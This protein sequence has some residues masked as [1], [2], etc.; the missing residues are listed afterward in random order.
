MVVAETLASFNAVKT[1]FDMAK[2][3]KDIHDAAERDRAVIDLQREILAAQEQQFELIRRVHEL[4]QKVARSD[5]WD[6]E[7]TPDSPQVVSPSAATGD[8]RGLQS[9]EFSRR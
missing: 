5:A 9:A 1:A 6:A 3:L 7:K 4:E 2:A 8:S